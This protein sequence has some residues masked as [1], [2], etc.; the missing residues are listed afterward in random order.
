MKKCCV[1]GLGYIGLP[2]SVILAKAGFNVIG[3]DINKKIVKQIN[4]GKEPFSEPDLEESLKEVIEKKSF[5]ARDKLDFADAFVIAVPT[6]FIKKNNDIPKPDISFVIKASEAIAKYIK[7]GN[8]ILIESTIPVG[9]T[10][11]VAKL[12]SRISKLGLNDFFIGHC[13]ERVLPGKI[14]YEL[15]NNDRVIGGLKES[16]SKICKTIYE[17]FC[18][19]N[20][21]VTNAKTAEMVKLAENS[22]RDINIAFA[23]ELS[24]ISDKYGIH[25]NELISLANNHPRVNILNPGCGVGGHCIAVDPWFIVDAFP[26]EAKLIKTARNVNLKKTSWVFNKIQKESKTFFEKFRRKPILGCLGISFK[27]NVDDIRE[28]PALQIVRELIKASESVLVSDPNIKNFSEFDLHDLN[29]L[30][31][32][33]DILIIL[34]NH[35][36]F[37]LNKFENILKNKKILDFCGK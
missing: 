15:V 13:P 25:S 21:Y 1:I 33:A 6:P 16:D 24:M 5:I 35:K 10:E 2:T 4:A 3:V 32:E 14:L 26:E 8:V 36:E 23:N 31:D 27:P 9:T 29:K 19:G 37:D 34:V 12:V 17:S 18:K 22:Y 20:I 7:K 11:K 28:S 30:L